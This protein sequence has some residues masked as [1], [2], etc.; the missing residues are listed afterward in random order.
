MQLLIYGK[1]IYEETM[2]V[3]IVGWGTI[4][5][6]HA[7]AL[8]SAENCSL[9]AACTTST[10][11]NKLI[12]NKYDIEIFNNYEDMLNSDLI[13]SVSICTPSGAHLDFAVEAARKKKNVIIEKPI[14][15]TV[16][17][18]KEIINACK[19]NDVALAIIYQ[20]RYLSSVKKI[21]EVIS[22]KQLGKIFHASAY[23][24][25][26]RDQEYYDSAAWRGTKKLDGGGVL[27][28]Q[29]I[30]TVDLLQ[31]FVGNVIEVSAFTG[32]FTHTNIEVE[33]SVTAILRFENEAIGVIEASTSI[34]PAQS[35]RIEIHGE[36]GSVILDGD[37]GVIKIDGYENENENL[38][39][40]KSSADSPLAGFSIIPHKNQFEEISN[41]IMN[42]E[43][44]SVSGV[45]ALKS[46]A[47]VEGIY[48]SS[49]DKRIISLEK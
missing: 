46:L 41:R 44:P 47:I 42:G 27:I 28:N 38:D 12:R 37:I 43:V 34:N 10:S 16:E 35:R 1:W 29:A 6:I 30:H 23:V 14:E 7:Q 5:D 33:D 24:K 31:Y 20:S 19:E 36:K 49:R 2:K 13:D 22:K 39:A 4:S 25:W 9:N 18:A 26:Y 21:K 3:G 45:E 11:K 15:V 8:V 40:S 17:R 48:H 32:A